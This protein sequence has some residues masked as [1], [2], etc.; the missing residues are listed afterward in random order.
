MVIEVKN[1]NGNVVRTI[2]TEDYKNTVVIGKSVIHCSPQPVSNEAMRN[3][4]K[5]DIRVYYA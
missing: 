3:I 1:K 5:S 4:L 2:K